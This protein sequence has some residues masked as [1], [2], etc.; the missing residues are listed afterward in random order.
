MYDTYIAF[1]APM[2]TYYGPTHTSVTQLGFFVWSVLEPH[3]VRGI[4]IKYNG[5]LSAVL[6]G[7]MAKIG[8]G[9]A[10]WVKVLDRY[11]MALF[12]ACIVSIPLFQAKM[13]IVD[14]LLL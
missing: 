8:E 10:C 13:R 6:A 3:V 14:V 7:V 5:K 4:A 1:K 11:L 2:M 12:W 9:L